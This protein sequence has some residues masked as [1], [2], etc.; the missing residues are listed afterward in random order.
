M[1]T[2]TGDRKRLATERIIFHLRSPLYRNGYLLTLS[3]A[4]SAGFGLVFWALAAHYYPPEIVG[5][6]S[7]VLSAMM[8]LAGVAVLSLNNVLLRYIQPAGQATY[9]LVAISY[10]LSVAACVVFSLIFLK[11]V[12]LW[13]P[14]LRFLG[15][16]PGWILAFTLAAVAWTIFSLQDYVL[17]GLR[18]T[19]WIPL[20]NILFSFAKIVLLILFARSLADLGIFAAWNIPVVL[21]LL[22][23][24]WLIVRYLIPQHIRATT[25]IAVPLIPRQIFTYATG[26]YLG[27]L[28]SLASTNLLPIVIATL[29]GAAANAYFFLPWTIANGLQLLALNMT[30]S[31]T[32]EGT[33]DQ[34]QLVVYCRRVLIQVAR[35]L[36]PV[37]IIILL[38]AP[39]FL[40]VFGREYAVKGTS[41]LRWLALATIPNVIVM[42]GISLAR[43]QNRARIVALVQGALSGLGLGLSIIL[44]PRLGIAGVGVA[45]L[46]SQTAVALWVGFAFLRP[47]LWNPNAVIRQ[48]A[49][50]PKSIN[51]ESR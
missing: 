24:N 44:L 45:W 46:C 15:D 22:P 29:A 48:P 10:A 3:S 38:G 36:V 33:L 41:L 9:R 37:V 7:A 31:L 39:F 42:L 17:T 19:Q 13:F 32:V 25:R 20:E 50:G 49:P 6:H 11:S 26:N 35:L 2:L 21:S 30:T 40:V 4:G 8:L 1:K 34:T 43:V 47:L 12:D 16:S 18:Q 28:F 5:L 23:V 27:T 14:S 51:P